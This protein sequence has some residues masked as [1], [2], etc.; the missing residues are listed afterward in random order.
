MAT[1]ATGEYKA[2]REIIEWLGRKI[3]EAYEAKERCVDF[4]YND[5]RFDAFQQAI[6]HCQDMLGRSSQVSDEIPNRDEE[7]PFRCQRDE[8]VTMD[9][10]T[11]D[12][13]GK[14][15]PSPVY[16]V[17]LAFNG[18]SKTATEVCADCMNHLKFKLTKTVPMEAYRD[19]EQWVM[20]HPKKNEDMK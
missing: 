3:D 2:L 12:L 5:G 10:H 19:Y 11:C 17:L 4:Q 20:A 1:N 13:C 16:P 6:N 9:M 18:Q 8:L 7:N 14:W 15:V